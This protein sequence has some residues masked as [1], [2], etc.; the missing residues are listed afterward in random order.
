MTKLDTCYSFPVDR[1]QKM[2][3]KRKRDG[4]SVMKRAMWFVAF[5]GR[6]QKFCNRKI[7]TLSSTDF[8]NTMQPATSGDEVD[9]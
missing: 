5:N 1:R 3:L 4:S 8:P 2:I 7:S 9:L 6:Q